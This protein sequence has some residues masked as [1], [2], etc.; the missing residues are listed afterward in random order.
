MARPEVEIVVLPERQH[1]HRRV[2]LLGVVGQGLLGQQGL[3]PVPGANH[4]TYI[5]WY[6]RNS[7]TRVG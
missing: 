7:C 3:H 2:E 4:A 6:L 5:G 1:L